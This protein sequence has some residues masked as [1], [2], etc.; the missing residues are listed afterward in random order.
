MRRGRKS[1]LC[2]PYEAD[3][4]LIRLEREVRHDALRDIDRKQIIDMIEN[5][6]HT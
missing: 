1:A 6:K 3:E 5:K 4:I 2:V